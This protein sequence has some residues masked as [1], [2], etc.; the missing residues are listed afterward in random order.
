[1]LIN[2]W[3]F[4]LNNAMWAGFGIVVGCCLALGRY[5]IIL[6]L[7]VV[8]VFIQVGWRMGRD[9]VRWWDKQRR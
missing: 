3:V 2:R 4:W 1:M 5:D 8:E 7:V 6:L 9:S